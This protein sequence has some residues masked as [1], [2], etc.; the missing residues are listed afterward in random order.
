MSRELI[1]LN[2]IDK[3][4][5]TSITCPAAVKLPVKVMVVWNASDRV[6]SGTSGKFIEVKDESL[7]VE[8]EGYSGLLLKRETWSKRNQDGQVF[9]NKTQFPVILFFACTAVVHCSEEFVPGLIYVAVSRVRTAEDIQILRFKPSQLFQPPADVLKVCSHSEEESADLT[10]CVNQQRS[11]RLWFPL[12]LQCAWTYLFPLYT[13]TEK[14]TQHHESEEVNFSV[15]DM[16]SEGLAKQRH[17]GRWAISKEPECYRRFIL[18]YSQ[19]TSTCQNVMIAHAK[20]DLLEEN[21][22]V[23]Y[24]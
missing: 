12:V 4:D 1:I 15:S 10:C 23:Q 3:G 2:A 21:I 6:K 17:V 11:L 22:I 18:V 9:G 13:V 8:I 7:K 19:S 20:C 14:L 16:P 24:G 5:V